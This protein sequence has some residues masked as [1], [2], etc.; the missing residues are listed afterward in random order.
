M[1]VAFNPRDPTTFASGSLDRTIK[2]WSITSGNNALFTLTG[3]EAGI[4][5]VDYWKTG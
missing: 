1:Q 5:C 4:N 3:H 2:I